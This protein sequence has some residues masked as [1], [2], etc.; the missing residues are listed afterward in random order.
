VTGSRYLLDTGAKRV[1]VD[2]GLFQGYKQLRLRNWSPPPIGPASIDAVILTHAHLDH[3]GYLPRLV[4]EGFTGPVYCSAGTR[5]LCRILLPDSGHLQEEE[6]RYANRAG[7]SKHHPA[8]PLYTLQD[9]DDCLKQF[10][11]VKVGSRWKPVE[12]IAAQFNPAGQ[13]PDVPVFLDSPMA[14]DATA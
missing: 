8:L 3:S 4:K 9:A 7:F 2:C 14:I 13:I 5:E 12:G 10:E 6:A 11:T 1:L